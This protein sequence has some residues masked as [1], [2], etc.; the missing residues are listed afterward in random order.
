MGLFVIVDGGSCHFRIGK[1][2]CKQRMT[3]GAEVPVVL[4]RSENH[5]ETLLS[6]GRGFLKL[7]Q[8]ATVSS[9]S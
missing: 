1:E 2:F 8:I 7:L 4:V 5:V 6:C 3:F 9:I